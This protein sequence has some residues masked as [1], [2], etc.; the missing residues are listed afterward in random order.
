M[1]SFSDKFIDAC[2]LHKKLTSLFRLF[3]PPAS[4]SGIAVTVSA[5]KQPQFGQKTPESQAPVADIF[6]HKA[7]T[8]T[9]A[10]CDDGRRK[11]PR[12]WP[13]F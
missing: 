12:E 9:P 13:F 1:P 2:A 7:P 5:L 4:P 10:L 6:Q 3:N 11:L 8:L